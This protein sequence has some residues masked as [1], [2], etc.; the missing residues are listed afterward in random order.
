MF[1]A[2]VIGRFGDGSNSNRL[3]V[4]PPADFMSGRVVRHEAPIGIRRWAEQQS[5]ISERSLF[6]GAPL[7]HQ[8]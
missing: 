7:F 3:V 6:S 2:A 4:V 5:E 8:G 1:Y